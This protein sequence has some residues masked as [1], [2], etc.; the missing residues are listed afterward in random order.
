MNRRQL[1]W[2]EIEGIEGCMI[3]G[4]MGV[5]VHYAMSKNKGAA[6]T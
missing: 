1:N 4:C 6:S 3:E 5:E 2:I